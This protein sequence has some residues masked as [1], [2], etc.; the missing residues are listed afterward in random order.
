MQSEFRQASLILTMAF[1]GVVFHAGFI[2]TSRNSRAAC[3]YGSD[4]SWQ[5]LTRCR[6]DLHHYAFSLISRDV[7]Y[8]SRDNIGEESW[9]S[10]FL[11]N[12]RHERLLTADYLPHSLKPEMEIVMMTAP[13]KGR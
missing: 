8:L 11:K 7:T 9:H 10:C 1:P 2:G 3:A 4:R 5:R 12:L 13:R 6:P